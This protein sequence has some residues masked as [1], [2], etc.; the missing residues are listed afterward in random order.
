MKLT[1]IAATLG[2]AA[3]LVTTCL[4]QSGSA[5]VPVP[6]GTLGVKAA[7]ANYSIAKGAAPAF[8]TQA[9]AKGGTAQFDLRVTNT[10]TAAT[11]YAISL[12]ARQNVPGAPS[13]M[14]PTTATVS[15]T[16]LLSQKALP[17]GPIGFVTP[18]VA[19]GKSAVFLVKVPVPAASPAGHAWLDVTL[20]TP[21]GTVQGTGQL[22]AEKKAVGVGTSAYDLT[23]TQ[24]SQ[25]PVGSSAYEAVI[26]APALVNQ[27]EATFTLKFTNNG[28]TTQGILIRAV[29]PPYC[30]QFKLGNQFSR[31]TTTNV[32]LS[33]NSVTPS[34]KPHTSKTYQVTLSKPSGNCTGAA[35]INNVVEIRAAAAILGQDPNV[36]DQTYHSVLL[37]APYGN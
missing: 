26:A 15:S 30:D 31:Q 33:G 23:V 13:E 1:H 29:Y 10:G 32:W 14:I 37:V 35:A 7:G 24:G 22:V 25:G 36:S 5:D 4:A 18:S 11:A 16:G 20:R 17:A 28:P 21:D 19:A 27:A 2:T 3:V 8:A 6:H 9:V 34:L 12:A